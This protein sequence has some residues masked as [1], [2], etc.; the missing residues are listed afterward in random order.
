MRTKLT[1]RRGETSELYIDRCIVNVSLTL[2]F[3]CRR[4]DGPVYEEVN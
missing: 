1:V 2:V 3:H 4:T